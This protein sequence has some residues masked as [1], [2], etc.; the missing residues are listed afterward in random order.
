[1][2]LS[3]CGKAVSNEG[4]LQKISSFFMIL[5]CCAKKVS[6]EGTK[7]AGV[8]SPSPLPPNPRP[9][10]FPLWKLPWSAG[11]VKMAYYMWGGFLLVGVGSIKVVGGDSVIF[12]FLVM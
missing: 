3:C 1:M 11:A 12:F 9:K 4:I 10:T 5:S 8:S 7:G 6:K 2:I